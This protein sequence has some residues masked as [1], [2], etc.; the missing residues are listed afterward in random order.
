VS[1][2]NFFD[3]HGVDNGPLHALANG[4]DGPNGLYAYSSSTAFPSSSFNAANYWVDVIVR[5]A[6]ASSTATPT[7]TATPSPT[8]TPTA[9]A[10]RTPTSACPCTIF[11][12]AAAPSSARGTDGNSV[13]VGVKFRSDADGFITGIRFY[14]LSVNTRAHVAH[15]WSGNGTLLATAAF[16]NES[17]SGWQQV[18]LSPPVRITAN[19]TY[20]A[21]YHTEGHYA[22]DQNYFTQSVDHPPLH[23]LANGTDGPNGVYTYSSSAAFPSSTF[24]AANYWVDVVFSP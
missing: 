22:G 7:R 17:A 5:P 15:L 4:D 12:A 18:S 11:P 3:G 10:T 24:N 14:K 2:Q 16:S 19:T 1:T 13:E 21:S 23:A 9:T 6:A 8:R 20:V